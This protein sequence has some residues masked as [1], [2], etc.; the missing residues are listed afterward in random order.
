MVVGTRR[1]PR[2]PHHE[3]PPRPAPQ[4]QY[5]LALFPRRDVSRIMDPQC[6]AVEWDTP[7]EVAAQAAMARDRDKLYDPILVTCRAGFPHR[8]GAKNPRRPGLRP[9]GDGQGGQSADPDCPATWPSS[10]RSPGA[11]WSA[12]PP[13][14]STSISTT[15]RSSTTSTASKRRQGHPHDRPHPGRGPGLQGRRGRFP[16]P[17]RRDD[18]V[19]LCACD[20]W[21]RS[22]GRPSSL[23]R[24]LAGPLRSRPE[25]GYIE[26]Q[27]ATAGLGRFGL[28]TVSMGVIDC[29]F[30]VAVTMDELGQRARA[31]SRNSPNRARAIPWCAT[32]ANPLGLPGDPANGVRLGKMKGE[33]RG[34]CS[35]GWGPEAPDPPNGENG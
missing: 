26:G 25:R 6:L 10:A 29:A 12:R 14:W 1:P 3:P 7:V 2:G 21:S 11:P 31:S 4:L 28:L 27:A 9:G 30:A 20:T 22:A 18:F 34:R 19:L 35:G 24:R 15:S 17:C 13:A 8:V 32:A 16:G 23:R 33:K 5:G